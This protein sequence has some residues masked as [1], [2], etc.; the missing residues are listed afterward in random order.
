MRERRTTAKPIHG[1]GTFVE[2]VTRSTAEVRDPNEHPKY[3]H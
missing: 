1:A 3:P 2:R